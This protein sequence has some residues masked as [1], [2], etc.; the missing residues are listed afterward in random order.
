MTGST[1]TRT[2]I[3]VSPASIV[4]LFTIA[5][6]ITVLLVGFVPV[7]MSLGMFRR[8]NMTNVWLIS[9]ARLA[10]RSAIAAILCYVSLYM[11]GRGRGPLTGKS[12]TAGMLVSGA[13]AG[14][15]DVVAHKLLVWRL[16]HAA[17]KSRIAGESLSVGLTA[18][19][20]LAVAA[21][22]VV[23]NVRATGERNY[24]LLE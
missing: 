6:S 12:V 9:L 14:A 10:V 13:L 21:L 7:N 19:V 22:L 15:L 2:T 1:P 18:V 23:R 24:E 3:S 4:A 11:T 16:I 8:V 20:V 5:Y 17:M